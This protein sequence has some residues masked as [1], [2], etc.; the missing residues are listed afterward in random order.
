MM[1]AT[2]NRERGPVDSE[3][4]DLS[5]DDE[6]RY[7]TTRLGCDAEQL[8]VA[9]QAVGVSAAAV[10]AYLGAGTPSRAAHGHDQRDGSSGAGSVSR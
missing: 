5:D 6:L 1:M 7:W 10:C 8:I 9:L 3:R 2:H 4:I